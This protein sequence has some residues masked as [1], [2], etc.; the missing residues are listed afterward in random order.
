MRGIGKRGEVISLKATESLS[1]T[2]A[3][4]GLRETK[5]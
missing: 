2:S 1:L 5:T 4:I 3:A